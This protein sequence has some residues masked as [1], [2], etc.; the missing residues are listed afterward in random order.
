MRRTSDCGE[1]TSEEAVRFFGS[2]PC[3]LDES[4]PLIKRI[5]RVLSSSPLV[6]RTQ[7]QRSPGYYPSA[8][9]RRP[10]LEV[11]FSLLIDLNM[12]SAPLLPANEILNFNGSKLNF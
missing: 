2:E 7:P 9:R 3:F 10:F 12:M 8:E 11:F 6:K 1:H 4:S 5:A